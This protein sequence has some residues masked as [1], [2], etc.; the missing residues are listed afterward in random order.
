MARLLSSFRFA[1]AMVANASAEDGVAAFYKGRTVTCYVGYG[2][3]GAYD[4]YAR[5]VS[6]YLSRHIPGQPKVIVENMPGA[7]S[8]VLWR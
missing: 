1:I 8:M 5:E 3:G 4:L 2:V 7:S 6:K